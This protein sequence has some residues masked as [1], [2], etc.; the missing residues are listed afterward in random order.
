MFNYGDIIIDK[1]GA[2]TQLILKDA[3]NPKR[4]ERRVLKCQEKYISARSVRDHGALKDM[5]SEMIAY[6]VQSGK[7]KNPYNKD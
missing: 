7:V 3:A 1:L 5:L 4:V 2:Q 6:H